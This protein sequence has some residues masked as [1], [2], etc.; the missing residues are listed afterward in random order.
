MRLSSFP[1]VFIS[2]PPEDKTRKRR[3]KRR[4]LFPSNSRSMT[5]DDMVFGRVFE[6]QGRKHRYINTEKDRFF[7]EDVLMKNIVSLSRKHLL[8]LIEHEMITMEGERNA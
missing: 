4:K 3:K 1:I 8:L 2:R 5:L 7:F 6:F